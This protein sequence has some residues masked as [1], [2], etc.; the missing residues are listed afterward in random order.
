MTISYKVRCHCGDVRA[1]AELN[2]DRVVAWE[3]D[4]SDCSMR[5]NGM[6]ANDMLCRDKIDDLHHRRRRHHGGY[7][8]VI[9]Y[10]KRVLMFQ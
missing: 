2:N 9:F 7:T 3:C 4:C 5:G 6:Y 10:L 1:I 8:F